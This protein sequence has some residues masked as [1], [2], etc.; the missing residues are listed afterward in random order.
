MPTRLEAGHTVTIPLPIVRWSAFGVA[1]ALATTMAGGSAAFGDSGPE[2]PGV[3]AVATAQGG[4]FT[5]TVPHY[6]AAEEVADGGGPLSQSYLDDSTTT[7]YAALPW[8]GENAIAFPG[9]FATFTGQSLPAGYPLYVTASNPS[10]PEQ[11]L[12]DPT[13]IYGLAAKATAGSTSGEAR[14]SSA[15]SPVSGGTRASTSVATNGETTTATAEN[16]NEALNVG[17]GALRIA[18]V[19]SRSVTTENRNGGRKTDTELVVSAAAADGTTLD[20]GPDGLVVAGQKALPA[21]EGLE[22]FNK[23]LEPAHL[24]VRIV[25]AEKIAGGESAAVLEIISDQPP[26]NGE[27]PGSVMTVRLG[28]ATSA[29]LSEPSAGPSPLPDDRLAP[30]APAGELSGVA[31]ES[32]ADTGIAPVSPAG[33]ATFSPADAAFSTP[34]SSPEALGDAVERDSTASESEEPRA[35][36]AQPALPSAARAAPR[37][38][39][40]RTQL[41]L[42]AARS[43]F[44]ALALAGGLITLVMAGLWLRPRGESA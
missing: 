31:G 44:G 35:T 30:G 20:Y 12:E 10:A 25:P 9:I 43:V 38:V 36:A 22:A 15:R 2:G 13:G 19:R 28:G 21:S 4:R 37:T 32:N 42:A 8:P 27:I 24:A 33:A 40:A 17:E 1:L 3:V 11:R 16:V 41:A 5:F 18:Y 23:A 26:P 7:S 39:A 29:V 14:L 34:A 6:A